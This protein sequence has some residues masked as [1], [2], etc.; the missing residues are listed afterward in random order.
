MCTEQ[1]L[2]NFRLLCLL[3]YDSKYEKNLYVC[4]RQCMNLLTYYKTLMVY[5]APSIIFIFHG[6]IILKIFAGVHA[7]AQW[8]SVL[9]KK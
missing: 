3:D 2:Q 9:S 7:T 8:N 1:K 6:W 4:M 5:R